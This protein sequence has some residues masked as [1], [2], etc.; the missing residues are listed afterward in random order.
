MPP[1]GQMPIVRGADGL[2]LVPGSDPSHPYGMQ[3]RGGFLGQRRG[4]GDV[5]CRHPD[6]DGPGWGSHP[7]SHGQSHPLGVGDAAEPG[8]GGAT[9]APEQSSVLRL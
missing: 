3:G 1:S 7:R 2:S 5:C 9:P 8:P 6:G 4:G